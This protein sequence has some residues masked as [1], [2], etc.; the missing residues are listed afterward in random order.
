MT[1]AELLAILIRTGTKGKSAVEISQSILTEFKN[2]AVVSNLSVT[3]LQKIKGIGPDKAVTLISAFEIAKRVQMQSKWQS[4]KIIKSPDDIAS[5]LI[6]M[7]KNEPKEKFLIAC[8]NKA[9]KLIKLVE[10]SVGSIDS[11]IV[12][13]REVFK[14]A[15]EN[16]SSSIIL[17][18]N[19]PSGNP[20]PSNADMKVTKQLVEV[21]TI[22]EIPVFDHIIIAGNKFFSFVE[23]KIL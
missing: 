2:L 3:D 1:D 23:E 4:D 17:V 8:L 20:K 19:H 22:M 21:G 13:P 6:P 5:L 14:S 9:N 10:I 16:L 11:S 15:I 7:L 12:H 18:H